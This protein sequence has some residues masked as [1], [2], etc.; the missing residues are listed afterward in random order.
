VQVAV[1]NMS[2]AV[3]GQL[4]LADDVFGV[5]FNETL[6]HQALVRQLANA[7]QGNAST[8]TRGE[9]AGSS[10]KLFAQKHTGH[11]RRGDI[12]SPLARHGGIVF[13][14]HPRL[15]T[16]AMPVKM[17]R[18]ALKCVLSAKVKEERLKIV[19]G[20]ELHEPKTKVMA[21]FLSAMKVD[22]PALVATAAVDSKIVLA[23]R[24]IP[25]VKTLP[26]SQL[27]VVD[28]LSY[29]MLIVSADAAKR[30]VELWGSDRTD[31]SAKVA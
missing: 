25:G 8:K 19:E 22:R 13:G 16:Q 24:N 18:L 1:Y 27:N 20:L 23:A 9:V 2:G 4:D 11:A 5:P 17:R 14:P 3:T 31:K 15:Y 29:G 10:R 12:R 28:L 7:R 6:V 21:E 30:M 26:V